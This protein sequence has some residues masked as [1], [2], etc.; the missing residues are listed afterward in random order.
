MFGAIGVYFG[1]QSGAGAKGAGFL[2]AGI[3]L[4]H[5]VFQA[6]VS[7]ATGF[8]EETWSRNLLNL[9]VTPLR[10]GE[11]V[12][13]VVLFG[14]AKLALG[15]SIVAI[16]ALALFA[17]DVTDIGLA[18]VPIVGLL[19]V[20]GW[21]VGLIVIGLILRVG[22]GAEILAW[23]LLA[24]LMPL[25]GIFYPVSALPGF[26]Q[27]IGTALPTT[28]IFVAA[29][30]VLEGNA[31]PW[32]ELA[33]AA[34][35]TAVLAVGAALVRRADARRLPEPRLHQP[36]RVTVLA[37]PRPNQP[38]SAGIEERSACSSASLRRLLTIS[39]MCS[40]PSPSVLP[41]RNR[42]WMPSTMI[43]SL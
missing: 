22:Q 10:E 11:Y 33:I 27:P 38:R 5:V 43:A 40:K 19:L 26:L 18:L 13:G 41:M 15:V 4:F 36:P 24:M 30:T 1:E 35:G 42:A 20:V 7:L 32:D 12:A 28:H 37:W 21:A 6:E 29:R 16:V 2:L 23:G 17:F 34:V 9:L 14:L 8:M 25:S 39:P 31:L 3:L